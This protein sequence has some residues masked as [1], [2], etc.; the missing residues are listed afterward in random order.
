MA[1]KKMMFQQVLDANMDFA[2]AKDVDFLL[3]KILA[4]ARKLSQAEVGS[5]YLFEGDVLRLHHTQNGKQ[6]TAAIPE[7]P[8]LYRASAGTIP[9]D[10]IPAYVAQTGESISLTAPFSAASPNTSPDRSHEQ[11]IFVEIQTVFA[12]PMLNTYNKIVGVIQL[13]NM[14]DEAGLFAV[15]SEDERPMVQLFANSAGSA[16][17]RALATRM[18]VQG[19]IQILTA[20]R[21]TEETFAHVNRVGAYAAEIYETWALR[22][23]EP[24]KEV[25]AKKDVLRM[26]AMLHDIGKLAIPSVIRKKPGKLTEEEYNTM[27]EHTLKGAQLLLKH[28]NS[29]IESA[30]A[31]IALTH[32]ERW[33][34]NGYPGYVDPL[35]GETLPNY[36]AQ[37]GQAQGK[38][39]EAIPV[40]GRIVAIADVYDA[41]SNH[42]VFRE[43]WKE[44]EVLQKLRT[45]TGT[46]F[47]PEM[48]DAFFSRLDTI[49]AISKRFPD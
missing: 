27:K 33:D 44:E 32:H 21:D 46:H 48:I 13:I 16:I 15:P 11:E 24:E 41:L 34:G 26:A 37:N 31:E 29:E 12:F 45:E 36:A 23:G 47:D 25:T 8:H 10:S 5:I 9:T 6:A 18:R 35:T 28:G 1:D 49:R 7:T 20:L 40:F 17:E 42:R 43:A 39:G 3:E 14:H 22:K 30:A 2:Q 4:T 19:I 38:Q